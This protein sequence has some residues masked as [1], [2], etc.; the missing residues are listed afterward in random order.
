MES[1][2]NDIESMITE[3]ETPSEPTVEEKI[4]QLGPEPSLVQVATVLLS[5]SSKAE[6]EAKQARKQLALNLA[7]TVNI[8]KTQHKDIDKLKT[9]MSNAEQHFGEMKGNQESLSNKM[10]QLQSV[11]HKTYIMTCENKQRSS[12][13]NFI[14]TGE[15]IPKFRPGED[16]MELVIN[17]VYNKYEF[18]I[19]PQEFKVLHR[20][21]GNRIIFALHNRLPGWSFEQLIKAMNTNPNSG[22]KVYVSIQ[23]FEPFSELYYIARRLKFYKIISY[24]RLDENGFTFIALNEQTRAFKFTSLDQLH[25]LQIKIPQVV[26]TEINERRRKIAESEANNAADNLKKAF[27][28]R[29]N[30]PPNSGPRQPNSNQFSFSRSQPKTAVQQQPARLPGPLSAPLSAPQSAPLSAPPSVPPSAPPSAPPSSRSN[31]AQLY[32]TPPPT[33]SPTIPR[34]SVPPPTSST[35]PPPSTQ[36]QFQFQAPH[37]GS[38]AGSSSTSST[39]RSPTF[40][41]RPPASEAPRQSVKD[42]QKVYMDHI[43]HAMSNNPTYNSWNAH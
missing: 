19:Q 11:V 8:V 27:D 13:G 12:K 21:P 2:L 43:E 1:F 37:W 29:P 38:A 6:F 4:A 31:A 34:P 40:G 16:L 7:E 17:L 18:Y 10:T 35:H 5:Q 20:L 30:P 32:Q 41:F 42:Q 24:Y 25:Q 15:Q 14:L 36:S 26:A 39:G 23:L 9:D 22:F 33:V 28:P 3:S